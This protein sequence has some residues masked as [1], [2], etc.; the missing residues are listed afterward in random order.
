LRLRESM[1]KSAFN[2]KKVIFYCNRMKAMENELHDKTKVDRG[3][4]NS[5][6]IE[7]QRTK[8]NK[9]FFV[10]QNWCVFFRRKKLINIANVVIQQ[11]IMINNFNSLFKKSNKYT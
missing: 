1:R 8:V 3:L 6:F 7:V 11:P 9:T 2:Q 5:W 10:I 4:L